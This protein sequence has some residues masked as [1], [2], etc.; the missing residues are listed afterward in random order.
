MSAA[1]YDL[2]LG[3]NMSWKLPTYAIMEALFAYPIFSTDWGMLKWKVK[4]W[5][6]LYVKYHPCARYGCL[7][8]YL[9]FF[10]NTVPEWGDQSSIELW[11][12]FRFGYS[13]SDAGFI[14]YNT[15]LFGQP[16]FGWYLVGYLKLI[17]VC[18][19]FQGWM[20]LLLPFEAEHRSLLNNCNFMDSRLYYSKLTLF[21]I[22]V[23]GPLNI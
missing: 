13:A 11:G 6:V 7:P 1:F 18:I 22:F 21:Y 15:R 19:F 14:W 12:C 17:L 8:L 23:Q 10:P 5:L 20:F 3:R 2:S 9:I 4:N 16:L